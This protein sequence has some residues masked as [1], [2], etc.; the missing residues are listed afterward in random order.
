MAS[1]VPG[2]SRYLWYLA[3]FA[4]VAVLLYQLA[5]ILSPFLFAA[6]LAYICVPLV[7]RLQSRR[8]PR[9]LSVLLV[10]VLLLVAIVGVV[11][12]LVPMVES[13]FSALLRHLPE[14]VD[15]VR[16]RLLP[17]VNST[18][19]LELKLD[20]AQVKQLLQQWFATESGVM[21]RLLP[22][23]TTG[24][25]ALVGFFTA[26]L[27]VPVVLFYFLRDWHGMVRRIDE[28]IPRRHHQGAATIVREIDGVLG[29]FL[30][31]QLAVIGLMSL[32]YVAALWLAGLEFALPIGILSGV[33]VFVPYLGATVGLL[34]ATLSG[35]VQFESLMPLIPVWIAFGVG[36]MLEGMV[37]TPWLIGDR[38]GLH[39]VLVIFAL[40]AFGQIFG[41][42]GV[43]LALP[44]S[45]ALLV[46]LR[47][48]RAQYLQSDL[49]NS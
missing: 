32:Y 31:G 37:V 19:G 3:A 44:A 28:L 14:Y 8:V 2:P 34:L 4:A 22:R 30:R 47:H 26:L 36:Q 12:V 5:P 24:G 17:W 11:L 6:T 1:L 41:F 43:L 45:A 40:L 46:A 15:W 48:L 20:F 21:Q 7:D 35:L 29:E 38:V 49:Y 25:L 39:P 9:T 33:L 13:Q 16:S 42:F 27:L 23:I 18:L 10:L